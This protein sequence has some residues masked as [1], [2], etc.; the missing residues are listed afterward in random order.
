[1]E[2]YPIGSVVHGKVRNITDFGIFIGLDEGIDGLVHVSDISW[3]QRLS[4]PL[5]LQKKVKILKSR[6]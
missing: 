4:N 2:R 1:M 3:N 5:K 6:Y